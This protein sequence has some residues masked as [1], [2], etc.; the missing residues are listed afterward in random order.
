M[1]KAKG[2]NDMIKKSKVDSQIFDLMQLRIRYLRRLTEIDHKL[3]C[4]HFG[5]N[6]GPLIYPGERQLFETKQFDT[7]VE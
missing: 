4:L 3:Y 7:K 2:R 6:S 1:V 5:L